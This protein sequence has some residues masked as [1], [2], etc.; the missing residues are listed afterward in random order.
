[1]FENNIIKM[2]MSR[3]LHNELELFKI[4]FLQTEWNDSSTEH[5][6]H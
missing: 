2:K 6:Q 1:M 4:K 3:Q 5:T